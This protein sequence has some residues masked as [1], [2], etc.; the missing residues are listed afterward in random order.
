VR[1]QA[2]ATPVHMQGGAYRTGVTGGYAY[3]SGWNTGGD[4]NVAWRAPTYAAMGAFMGAS[5][6]SAQPV[7]YGYGTG[8]NV[9]YEN[10]TV[11]VDGQASGTPEQYAQQALSYVESAPPPEKVDQEEWMPLGVFAFTQEDM[12]DS[13][14]MIE[15]AVSKSGVLAGTY[16]NET[17]G[18]SR[19]LKGS[20]DTKSQRA[21][22]GFADG[23]NT[24]VALETGLYNL[25]Q[26]EAPSLLHRGTDEAPSLL[27]RGTDDS[28]P[29]LLVRLPP[30]ADSD[31][32]Q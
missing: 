6:A 16:Y 5:L 20:V 9:Y 13:N 15:L 22:M 8:G 10:N 24:N 7:Y 18:S 17:T 2:I 14:T 3:Y 30:P 27:H 25:T 32:K 1:T 11:Y 23:K 26:D 12:T 4:I 31:S 28:S 19:P 29:V 21:V